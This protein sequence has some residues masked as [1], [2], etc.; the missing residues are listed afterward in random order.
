[1]NS[2]EFK[3]KC[4]REAILKNVSNLLLDRSYAIQV[5]QF[6]VKER[7][8]SKGNIRVELSRKINILSND[9]VDSILEECKREKLISVIASGT[10]GDMYDL[11]PRFKDLLLETV[12]KEIENL[13]ENS[14]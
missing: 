10:D 1:M 4:V 12:F 8:A 5:I 13:I 14:K 11:N 6:L 3:N 7:V 9:E 2:Q